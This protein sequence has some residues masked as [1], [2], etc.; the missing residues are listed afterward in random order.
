MTE[1]QNR[2]GR[3]H[4]LTRK[5]IAHLLAEGETLSRLGTVVEAMH[6]GL[7]TREYDDVA[8][9]AMSDEFE[10]LQ[11]MAASRDKLRNA[12]S[13]VLNVPK[14]TATV[15]LLAA[16]L[17]A[18]Q[19]ESLDTARNQVILRAEDLN[20]QLNGTRNLANCLYMLISGVFTALA[21]EAPAPE[22]YNRAGQN[23]LQAAK[24][25]V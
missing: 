16:N 3:L 6:H 11:K 8:T 13:E 18:E 4:E 23:Q 22:V 14:S 25:I 2:S 21:G 5:C 1:K 12:I 15:R 7:S 17:E 9:L 19:R 24:P 20:R 10:Q